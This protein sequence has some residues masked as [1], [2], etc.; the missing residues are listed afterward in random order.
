[1]ESGR[2]VVGGRGTAGRS[3]QRFEQLVVEAL[4][5]LPEEFRRRLENVEIVVEDWPSAYTL[6]QAGVGSGQTLFGLYQGIP[7]T[8]RTS[9]Y[10]LVLPDKI[11]LYRGPLEAYSRSDEELREHVAH[12]VIHEIAHF[13]GISDDRL[14]E[15]GVY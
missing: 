7:L 2:R 1:M 4:E 15:M 10:N 13:F 14:R 11:T 12:T 6:R 9:G 8:E 5:S 3:W